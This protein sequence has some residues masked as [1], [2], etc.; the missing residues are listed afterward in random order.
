MGFVWREKQH[1]KQTQT[2]IHACVLHLYFCVH[3]CVSLFCCVLFS[4][5]LSLCLSVSLSLCLSLSLFCVCVCVC[6][7]VCCVFFFG[8]FVL[9][10]FFCVHVCVCM[11]VCACVCVHVLCVHVCV[12][13]S[14]L[15]VLCAVCWEVL[16]AVSV[17]FT[18]SQKTYMHDFRVVLV[19]WRLRCVLCVTPLNA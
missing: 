6:V 19:C 10:I 17:F 13:C 4:L 18:P 12:L 15:Y 11:C 1:N 3:V 16:W 5:S 8:F 2:L 9:D 7:C 14:M